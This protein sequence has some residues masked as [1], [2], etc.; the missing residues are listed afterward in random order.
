MKNSQEIIIFSRLGIRPTSVRIVVFR[1]ISK[2][3]NTFNLQDVEDEL[4]WMDKSS[5][6]RTLNLFAA[7]S[8]LHTIN[9]GSGTQKY[10][11]CHHP[12]ECDSHEM[13]C[14]F[15]CVKCGTTYCLSSV[16]PSHINLPE[17]FVVEK[18]SYIIDGVC[19]SCSAK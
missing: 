10:C 16:Y 11:L 5:I 17:G 13:H 14:H 2:F 3:K 8:L 7:K 12:G 1:A 19:S 15:H 9:D 6:F 4:S 18:V